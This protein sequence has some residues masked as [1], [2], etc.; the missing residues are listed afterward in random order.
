MWVIMMAAMMLPSAPMFLCFAALSRSRNE[1]TRTLLF[2]LAYLALWI[3]FSVAATAAQ[4]ALQLIGLISPMIVSR[5]S[6]L[7]GG[8]L[9]IAGLFQFSRI[10]HACML[11]CVSL[12]ARLLAER[13]ASGALGCLGDGDAPRVL[14]SWLLLG[15]DGPALRRRRHES[16]LDCR[17]P[18]PCFVRKTCTERRIGRAGARR[19]HDWR[20]CREMGLDFTAMRRLRPASTKVCWHAKTPL[21]CWSDGAL[22][23]PVV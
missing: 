4:W 2:V 12:A 14:L 10:K 3:A 7:S 8:L 23:G 20:G 15:A 1:G 9:L 19:R 21:W 11:A 18:W 13:L 22:R 5:S 16:S 6:V 17:S